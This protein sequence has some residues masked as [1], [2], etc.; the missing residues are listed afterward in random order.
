M[1]LALPAAPASG[2]TLLGEGKASARQAP[3]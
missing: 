3:S 1:T 2:E